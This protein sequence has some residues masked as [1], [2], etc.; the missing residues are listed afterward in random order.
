MA[1]NEE[2]WFEDMV[3]Q[4]HNKTPVLLVLGVASREYTALDIS[5]IFTDNK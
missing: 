5:N 1:T 3:A 2:T 4:R